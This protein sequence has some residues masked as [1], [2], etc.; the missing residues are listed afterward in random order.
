MAEIVMTY[1][2]MALYARPKH[3]ADCIVMAYIGMAYVVM[4]YIVM[5]YTAMAYIVMAYIIEADIMM[6]YVVMADARPKH[7]AENIVKAFMVMPYTVLAYIV[8]VDARPKNIACNKTAAGKGLEAHRRA[9]SW[10]TGH[11]YVGNSWAE[12]QP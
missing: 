10:T 8:M 6:A 3:V 12:R 5:A 7:V 4:A 1:I 9:P 11:N 2:V